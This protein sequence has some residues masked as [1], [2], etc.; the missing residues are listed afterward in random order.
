MKVVFERCEKTMEQSGIQ[1]Y[2]KVTINRLLW[3]G[4]NEAATSGQVKGRRQFEFKLMMLLVALAKFHL[5]YEKQ[6]LE[7][8]RDSIISHVASANILYNTV[9]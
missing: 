5:Y 2:G 3:H 6:G 9:G 1:Y 8:S 4:A 7:S